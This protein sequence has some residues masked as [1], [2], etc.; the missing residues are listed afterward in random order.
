M[1]RWWLDELAHAGAE[2]LDTSYVAGYER[3][4]G[5]D[6]ADDLELLTAWGLGRDSVLID[7]GAGPG[8]FALAAAAVCRRVI[9]V[10]VSPAMTGLLA[11]RVRRLGLGNVE[12]IQAGLLSYEYRGTPADFVF[13]RNTLH[14]IPDFWK[15]IALSR[16][17]EVMR[18]GGLLRLHDLVFDFEPADAGYAIEAWMSGAVEDPA[19]GYTAGE[20]A[21]HVRTEHSTYSWLLEPLLDRTGFTILDREYYRSAY[22]AYLCLRRA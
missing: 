17:A 11:E 21:E 10:D 14:Q 22:G 12:V 20:L 5:Y 1:K 13:T 8:T 2:H 15:G 3:K 4:G 19:A 18:P 7:L 9:A 16:M 6:P